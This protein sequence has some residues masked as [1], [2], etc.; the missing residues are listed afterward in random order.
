MFDF[1]NN[2]DAGRPHCGD[3][4]HM[5]LRRGRSIELGSG[6][7][8]MQIGILDGIFDDSAHEYKR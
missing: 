7:N 3:P 8:C 6:E 1:L 2:V 4:L 5:A